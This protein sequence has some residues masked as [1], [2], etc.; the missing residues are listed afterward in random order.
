MEVFSPE[1]V[2]R[3]CKEFALIPGPALDLAIGYDFSR[4]SDRTKAIEILK[5]EEPALITL[6]PPCTE[7]SRLQKLNRHIHGQSYV[8]EHD[9]LKA[10]AVRH[11]EFCIKIAKMQ[12]RR[13]RW[14]VFEHPAHGDTWGEPCMQAF[15]KVPD[16][17]WRIA[18]QCQYGLMTKGPDG[19]EH[20]AL[21]PTR[22]VSNSWYILEE[23]CKRCPRVHRHE[24]LMG[25][26][27]AAAAIYPD[28]L[29]R[30]FCRGLV[31]QKQFEKERLAAT[32]RKGRN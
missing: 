6:S 23:F 7:F 18:D 4:S 25:G 3:V 10:E 9:M 27:A 1:R 16:V 32:A 20:P 24:P 11:V 22:F 31:R 13:G 30:A 19:L 8:E 17:E 5:R 28:D 12:M 15:L 21:K 2:G 14:F 29:C 26:K